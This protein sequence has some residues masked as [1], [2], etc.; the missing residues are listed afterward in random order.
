MRVPIHAS[1]KVSNM[2]R[3][4]ANTAM[5]FLLLGAALAVQAEETLEVQNPVV[6]AVPAFMKTTAGFMTLV[7]RTDQARMIVGASSPKA[8]VIELHMH[9]NDDG[10]MRMRRIPHIHLPPGQAVRLQ[11]GG[12]HLM[13]FELKEPLNKGDAVAIELT[14]DDGNRVAVNATVE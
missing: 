6:R 11:P 8:G 3:L 12:L 13:I 4:L 5:S 10:V 9:T 7:N 14:L 2:T 1:A